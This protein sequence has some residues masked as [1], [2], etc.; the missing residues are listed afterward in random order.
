[1]KV[2]QGHR[3]REIAAVL[4]ILMKFHAFP[5]DMQESTV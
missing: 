2:P 5:S 3:K 1:M 4:G